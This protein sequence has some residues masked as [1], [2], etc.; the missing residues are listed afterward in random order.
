[1]LFWTLRKRRLVKSDRPLRDLSNI[2]SLSMKYCIRTVWLGNSPCVLVGIIFL[3][4]ETFYDTYLSTEIGNKF[5]PKML[6]RNF[7]RSWK[8]RCNLLSPNIEN[9]LRAQIYTPIFPGW[10]C[11]NIANRVVALYRTK[12]V[13]NFFFGIP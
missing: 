7:K 3:D 11:K 8:K 2:R 9:L 13:A 5:H 6:P 12:V 4:K 10:S 1:M